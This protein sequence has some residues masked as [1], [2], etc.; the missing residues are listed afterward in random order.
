MRL[1]FIK[2]ETLYIIG[3]KI[4]V[5]LASLKKN[6]IFKIAKEQKDSYYSEGGG[7]LN[8]Q[9]K[10]GGLIVFSNSIPPAS[11]PDSTMVQ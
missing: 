8:R 6:P 7:N 3:P 9:L 1:H 11:N 4:E 10:L 5:T 2:F